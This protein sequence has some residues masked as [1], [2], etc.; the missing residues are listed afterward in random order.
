MTWTPRESGS[1]CFASSPNRYRR[2]GV[3][4]WSIISD[5]AYKAA[6]ARRRWALGLIV[7]TGPNA[8][9]RDRLVELKQGAV[10]AGRSLAAISVSD[11]LV[12]LAGVEIETI[13]DFMS[14]LAGLKVGEPAEMAVLRDGTRLRL[15]VVPVSRE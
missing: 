1:W 5:L 8:A 7:V 2:N 11:V 14:A 9:A 3:A 15:E 13:H 4:T 10:A 6:E 12:G